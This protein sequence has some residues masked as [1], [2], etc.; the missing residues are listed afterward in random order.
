MAHQQ[1][2]CRKK[3]CHMVLKKTKMA[4]MRHGDLIR[5]IG[6]KFQVLSKGILSILNRIKTHP[7]LNTQNFIL[8]LTNFEDSVFLFRHELRENR[9]LLMRCAGICSIKKYEIGFFKE[10]YPTMTIFVWLAPTRSG[11][12]DC[13]TYGQRRRNNDGY[14]IALCSLQWYFP[15]EN[16]GSKCTFQLKC[17]GVDTTSQKRG[18]LFSGCKIVRLDTSASGDNR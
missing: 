8:L 15:L 1:K 10:Y 16:Q 17:V 9:I 7:S 14:Q 11:F 12:I 5:Q 13:Q 4:S 6:V 3:F 18:S 2:P